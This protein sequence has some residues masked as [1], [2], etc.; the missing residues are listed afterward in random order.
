MSLMSGARSA[1]FLQHPLLSVPQTCLK[2]FEIALQEKELNPSNPGP[3]T[4][5]MGWVEK[6]IS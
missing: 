6:A 3:V 5:V 2:V 4:A 1:P